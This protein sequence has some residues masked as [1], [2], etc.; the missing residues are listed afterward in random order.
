[1]NPAGVKSSSVVA[2]SANDSKRQ[3]LRDSAVWENKNYQKVQL[4]HLLWLKHAKALPIGYSVKNEATYN[5]K[6][7][8]LSWRAHY[9]KKLQ[10]MEKKVDEM[11]SG[12]HQQTTFK[13]IFI[14][15]SIALVK[16]YP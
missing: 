9:G 7:V 10:V 3:Y 5:L 8:H 6:S 16:G 14:E 4:F 12:K 11:L 13:Y 1:M 2:V 15:K